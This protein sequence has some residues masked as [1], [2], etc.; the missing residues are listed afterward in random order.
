[1][2]ALN[3]EANIEAAIQDTLSAFDAFGIDGEIIVVDD[4]STDRTGEHVA[5]LCATEPRVRVRTHD[6]TMGLGFSFWDGVQA[7]H[8]ELVM[9]IPGDNEVRAADAFVYADLMRQVDILVPFFVNVEVRDRFRRIVSSLYRFVVNV[10]FGVNLNYTNGP[11]VYRRCVL[12]D[13][14]L[15]SSGFFYQT[16]LLVKL[17]RAGYLFA[18]A[19]QFLRKRAA[20]RS[21][22]I[23]LSSLMNVA[24]SYLR[25]AYEIHLKRTDSHRT[26]AQQL[27]PGSVSVRRWREGRM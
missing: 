27:D 24:G 8:Q 12:R 5:R 14:L 19:P 6:R 21:K 13:D 22:A 3:E 18:E 1:M 16:E 25:L 10:S 9:L 23:S 7:A 2:P 4:G 20:G 11:V 17:I 26:R 15:A